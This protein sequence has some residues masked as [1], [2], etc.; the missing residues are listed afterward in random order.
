M[1]GIAGWINVSEDIS[2][3]QYIIK[4]MTDTLSKRG[5]DDSGYYYSKNALLGHRRLVVVDPAGGAQPMTKTINNNLY[6]IVYNGELYNTEDLRKILIEAGFTFNSYSDTEVLLTSYIYWGR[7]CVNHINGIYAFA[8]W[9]EKEK[10]I[11]LARDPLGVKPL[12]YTIKNHSL[13]FGSEIKTLLAHPGVEPIVD[14]EGLTELFALGP[15][16]PLGSGIFKDILEIA[17]ANYMF[18]SK[19]KKDIVEYWKPGCIKHEENIDDTADHVRA[20]LIDSIRRQLG[21]DVPVC[22]FLS[23]GLDSSAIS[24]VAAEE[25]KK[26]G[27]ILNTFSIDYED[28]NL[29]FKANDFQPTSDSDFAIKMKD[30]IGSNHTNV[31]LNSYNLKNALFDA[32]RAN[33]LPG[34]A[35][36]DSSLFLFCKEV[37]KHATVAVSGECADEIFGG[38]PWF[39]KKEF[40]NANTFPWSISLN[41]R[42]TILSDSLKKLDIENYVRDQYENTLKQ[43]PHMDSETPYEYR[44]RE[45]FY[46][47]IKWFMITLLNRKDRMSM[48]NSLEVRVPFADYRL[49]EYAFNI[50]SNI[51][52]CDNKEKGIL[53]RALKGILPDEIVERK[54]SPYP[55]THNPNYTLLVQEEM[56]NIL[57]DKKSPILPLI[58]FNQVLRLVQT[59]GKS[60]TKPW[61]GQLMTGPQ[62]LAYLIQIN[63]WLKEY[64]VQIIK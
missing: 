25:F 27:K 13:I 17:P 63:Y 46:L 36:V 53:R 41:E 34:M 32:V 54:K 49:V 45:L 47:N 18:Y 11:F 58:D 37:R 10:S 40:I 50:P 3:K 6:V 22:T 4:N 48:G 5:P 60:Y 29:Y 16:R 24:A 12:F 15:A 55:K 8:V 39:R 64:N 62:L 26:Q 9:N 28:N 14:S 52:F 38:Y 35:D 19:D 61:F 7:E 56:N 23:G 21:A 33:D 51:K 30:F 59:G 43:V 31:M 57:N 20:L 1:C 2:D 44:M 42:K